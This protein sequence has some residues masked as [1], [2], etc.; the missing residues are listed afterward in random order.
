M[1]LYL[2]NGARVPE[3]FSRALEYSSIFTTKLCDF[4][5]AN[6]CQIKITDVWKYK[7]YGFMFNLRFY[8]R[9]VIY[10]LSCQVNVLLF[11]PV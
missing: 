4:I 9:R 10:R 6:K 11:T 3:L 1:L 2:S 7:I 8:T 5:I